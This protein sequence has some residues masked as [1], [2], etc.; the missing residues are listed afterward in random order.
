MSVSSLFN[1]ELQTVDAGK[2]FFYSVNG[3]WA[4]N[5]W[6]VSG[7]D[8]TGGSDAAC[9]H[10]ASEALYQMGFRFWT[11]QKTTRPAMIPE[12]GVTLARQEFSL[13]Y[14]NL[15]TN[16]SF[17]SDPTLD[18]SFARWRVLN[19]C[20]D[21]RRP[22]GHAWPG[23]IS[24]IEAEDG[25]FTTNPTFYT[26]TIGQANASF[27]L[28]LGASDLATLRDRVALH[29][30]TRL[31]AEGRASFDPQDGSTWTSE[32]VWGF[33][34]DVVSKIRE[35]ES[36][37]KLGLYAYA[38]HRAPVAFECPHLYCQIALGFNDL[39]IGYPA[40]VAAWAAVVPEIALRGY[41]IIAAQNEW[42]PFERGI[43]KRNSLE[44]Y[45]SY[46]LSGANGVNME[47]TA[48]WCPGV[49]GHYR[50]LRYW[51]DSETTY[52]QVLEDAVVRLYNNDSN[53]RDLFMYWSGLDASEFNSSL[54]RSNDII[55][56][57]PDSEHKTEFQR[58][59]TWLMQHRRLT[60]NT[61][62]HSPLYFVRLEKNL[63][64]SSGME[65]LGT[66]HHYAYARQLAN[67]NTSNNGRPDLSFDAS[68][69]WD[70]YPELPTTQDW[71]AQ[72]TE[73]ERA[74]DR[75]VELDDP[76]RVLATVTPD[77]TEAADLLSATDFL[78][79]GT[80]TFLFVGPGS[81]T[82][83]YD[84]EQFLDTTTEYGAGLHEF[85]IFAEAT[86]SFSGG[87]LFLR[88]FP[89]VRMDPASSGGR[90]FL[91]VPK[92]VRGRLLLQSDS[93]LT[94]FDAA[95]RKDIKE[96]LPPFSSGFADPRVLRAGHLR[97]DNTNTRGI[98]GFANI[99]PYIS[100]SPYR[101]LMP[102]ALAIRE[103]LSF[104]ELAQ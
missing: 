63:R 88:A 25:F 37:A 65:Q 84:R 21:Q 96:N 45:D 6:Q 8:V 13:P 52:E 18:A 81:V 56:D 91:F 19:C 28:D 70:R 40:L 59:M 31:N 36:D 48:S 24:S 80:A 49:I 30:S 89:A 98:H 74:S 93:R 11:P 103:G 83:N 67:S 23:L 33:A 46:I 62:E 78:T 41:G 26:G 55:A 54:K 4:T 27:N 64:W 87:M 15:Y 47:T 44:D 72:R 5:E 12:A 1:D 82:V 35:T 66:V 58:Y 99:N 43:L 76:V 32:Q 95:G 79:L 29:L 60:V 3:A 61:T 34:N 22:V 77:T 92:M 51:R 85:S 14:Q 73:I 9:E 50:A 104:E 101:M 86:T 102:R 90:R 94:V 20:G 68:A 17:G 69:H 71:S 75:P 100:P 42:G 57:M 7:F 53:V 10:G 39:G 2:S 16:Y 38:G 97:I